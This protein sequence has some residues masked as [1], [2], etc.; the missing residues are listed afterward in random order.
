MDGVGVVGSVGGEEGGPE[1]FGFIYEER[2]GAVGD[3][4]PGV[5]EAPWVGGVES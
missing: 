5:G 3:G 1:G 2:E 4:G